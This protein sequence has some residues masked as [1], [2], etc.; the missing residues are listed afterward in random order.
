MKKSPMKKPAMKKGA[1]TPAK[2]PTKGGKGGGSILIGLI[3]LLGAA[4]YYSSGR[5]YRSRD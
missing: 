3:F 4:F 5:K 2:T 1:K